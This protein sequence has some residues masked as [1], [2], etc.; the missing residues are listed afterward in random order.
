MRAAGVPDWY[1]NSCKKIAYL[2]PKAHAVAYVM[3][4]FR[5]AWFKVHRPLAFYAA[6]FSIRAKAFDEKFMCRG[7]DVCQKKMREIIAKDKEATAVEQDMLITLEVCY[8]FYLRGFHF[9]RLDLYKSQAIHFAMDEEKGTLI[10]PF[11]S[12]AG[13]GETAA[14]SLAE[15]A[16]DRHFISIEE[17]TAA[18]PKVS[19]THIEMLKEAGAFGDMPE[20]SQIDLFSLFG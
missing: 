11:V 14:I 15:Q 5:I 6:F 8:E 4:A 16:R 3:M 13:L 1:I 2:F 20:T 9:E 19:K 7:M 12:V 17:V 18:C 10:P